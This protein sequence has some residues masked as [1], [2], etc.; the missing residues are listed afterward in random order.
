MATPKM[1]FSF[2]ARPADRMSNVC[3]SFMNNH[4]KNELKRFNF[5]RQFLTCTHLGKAFLNNASRIQTQPGKGK[6][7]HP[8]E[9]NT[10]K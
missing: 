6:P 2:S 5:K 7:K 4:Q 8:N 9:Q 3:S 10:R 1:F